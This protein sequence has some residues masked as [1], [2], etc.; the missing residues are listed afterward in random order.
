MPECRH[1]FHGYSRSKD[2][3]NT[4]KNC[5][6]TSTCTVRPWTFKYSADER[7]FV[8][9]HQNRRGE[10][11]NFLFYDNTTVA[12]SYGKLT[13]RFYPLDTYHLHPGRTGG[14]ASE[15]F[16]ARPQIS[17]NYTTNEVADKDF[18]PQYVWYWLWVDDDSFALRVMGNVGGEGTATTASEWVW[19]GPMKAREDEN[20][21]FLDPG[22]GI[23]TGSGNP[24]I[25]KG[26]IENTINKIPRFWNDTSM[27][28]A[29]PI[30][31]R[32]YSSLIP[33]MSSATAP[34]GSVSVSHPVF[35]T[36]YSNSTA[37]SPYLVFRNS[38]LTGNGW[39]SGAWVPNTT[40]PS[41]IQY[42]FPS[43]TTI[44]EFSI[45]CE[46]GTLAYISYYRYN[47]TAKI[48]DIKLMGSNDGN[49]WTELG[50]WSDL[51]N[52]GQNLKRLQLNT[53]A[54]YSKYRWILTPVTGG[55]AAVYS[56]SV[57]DHTHPSI[58]EY[59]YEPLIKSTTQSMNKNFIGFNAIIDSDTMIRTLRTGYMYNSDIIAIE[60]KNTDYTAH[61]SADT[62]AEGQIN[63]LI[64]RAE[65]PH[66][67]TAAASGNS[68]NLSWTNP[69]KFKGIRILRSTTNHYMQRQTDGM[70]VFDSVIN[71]VQQTPGGQSS[72]TD[73]GLTS[74][75][76]YCYAVV[77]YDSNE[78]VSTPLLSGRAEV[79]I[80]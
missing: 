76:T 33:D 60:G 35:N 3:L 13:M 42:D 18:L 12:D 27:S 63:C 23:L 43:P 45:L 37:Q 20:Y 49:G 11:D 56:I 48:K 14:D 2:F 44:T 65:C 74:G 34:S 16:L 38:A 77:A 53:H 28:L 61:T 41:W 26:S 79:S 69:T 57:G 29:T 51:W 62:S 46:N 30:S 1:Y 50:S 64:K 75:Q 47:L 59:G 8:L 70:V 32:Q 31:G 54:N 15:G 21:I 80:P 71:D 19:Y 52:T 17:L 66:T 73:P 78:N 67:L 58:T 22:F 4:L 36:G 7:S 72:W 5:F 25:E 55:Y 68:V 6:L 24:I 9:S 40:E 39:V 10:I